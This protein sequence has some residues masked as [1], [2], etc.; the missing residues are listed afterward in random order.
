MFSI[1]YF[2]NFHQLE[3]ILICQSSNHTSLK[4]I[5]STYF[6]SKVDIF[7]SSIDFEGEGWKILFQ[8]VYSIIHKWRNIS[9][10]GWV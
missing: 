7:Y 9:I 10:L 6:I 1:E 3:W 4:M 2:I 5:L 8:A